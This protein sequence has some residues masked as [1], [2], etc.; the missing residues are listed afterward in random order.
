MFDLFFIMSLI[1]LLL[2]AVG[3]IL[4]YVL[5]S[6]LNLIFWMKEF[7]YILGGAVL[8]MLIQFT[9]TQPFLLS[10]PI[11]VKIHYSLVLLSGLIMAW[12][13]ISLTQYIKNIRV[14][15]TCLSILTLSVLVL[16]WLGIKTDIFLFIFPMF[17]LVPSITVLL[18]SKVISRKEYGKD[19]IRLAIVSLVG[20]S[21]EIL[22]YVIIKI[23]PSISYLPMGFLTFSFFS[24]I[25]SIMSIYFSL[26]T[27]HQLKGQLSS[28]VPSEEQI[29]HFCETNELTSRES[30]IVNKLLLR[31][32]HREIASQLNISPRTVERHVYN[33]YQKT[34]LSSRFELYDIIRIS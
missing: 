26:K 30:Q 31:F 17:I 20:Y 11:G 33:I 32:T 12:G 18:N 19:L 8:M 34:G 29:V 4:T 6:L 1:I 7:L 5:H 25:I 13:Y 22:E 9:A 23:Y 16:N 15:H 27:L 28:G 24:L 14:V 2:S 3:F 21:F 10:T